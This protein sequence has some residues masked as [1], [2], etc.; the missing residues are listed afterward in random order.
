MVTRMNL[1]AF[2]PRPARLSGRKRISGITLL[3]VLTVITIVAILM[4]LGVPSYQYVTSSNRISGEVNALLG[5]LQYARAEAIKEGQTVSVCSSTNSTTTAPTCSGNTSWQNGWIV[6]SDVNG[7]GAVDSASDT[8]LRVQR[9]FPLGDTFNANKG[10]KFVTFNR[11][12][13]ALNLNAPP[14]TVTLHAAV[15]STGSTRCLQITIVG[16]L[17]TETAGTGACT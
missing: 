15:P 14:V 13:F 12:G 1:L 4:A 8:I 2:N 11:E 9:P 6:F 16:Q 7:S 17:T 3:E 10:M 5:D